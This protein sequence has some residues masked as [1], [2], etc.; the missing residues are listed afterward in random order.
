MTRVE[1][2]A[3]KVARSA[4]DHICADHAVGADTRIHVRDEN[5]V[6]RVT[7]RTM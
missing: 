2:S 4:G 3:R 7:R 5:G 1:V 6:A